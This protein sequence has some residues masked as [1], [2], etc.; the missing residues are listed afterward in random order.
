MTQPFCPS[1][2]RCIFQLVL[3]TV[4][5]SESVSHSIM[6]NSLWPHELLST[7]LLC[8]WNSP[9]KNISKAKANLLSRVRLF[10]T[11]WTVAHQ[12]P[13]FMEFFRQEY[14]SGLPFSSPGDLPDAGRFFT[15]WA[16]KEFWMALIYK[17]GIAINISFSVAQH[18]GWRSALVL[19]A[20]APILE[21][22]V[23]EKQPSS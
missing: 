6:S 21:L 8:P 10:V 2:F 20:C 19:C 18:G 23:E 3:C 12:T 4:L 14:R 22:Q 17:H 16:T 1:K 11:P 13:P 15:V 9:G 5:K 7:R